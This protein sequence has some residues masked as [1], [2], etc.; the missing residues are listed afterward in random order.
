MWA[1]ATAQARYSHNCREWQGGWVPQGADPLV[2]LLWLLYA[3]GLMCIMGATI[4][5][6]NVQPLLCGTPYWWSQLTIG[7][8]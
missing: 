4:G 6:A 1:A 7:A 3:W 5:P 8:R 2:G